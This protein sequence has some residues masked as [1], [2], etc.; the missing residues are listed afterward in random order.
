MNNNYQKNIIEMKEDKE[1]T[2][3]TQ[4]PDYAILLMASQ[5]IS[6][7]STNPNP[8]N[9]GGINS[10]LGGSGTGSGMGLNIGGNSGLANSGIDLATG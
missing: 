5:P 2:K 10:G 3:I 8:N 6:A 7:M 9:S 1:I 4:I